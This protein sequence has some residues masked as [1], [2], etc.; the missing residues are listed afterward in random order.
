MEH[1]KI[2][3]AY[4]LPVS[5]RG[6][7]SFIEMAMHLPADNFETILITVKKRPKDP[8]YIDQFGHK[9]FYLF[10]EEQENSRFT[11]G[12][13]RKLVNILKAEKIDILHAHRHRPSSYAC[14]AKLFL[15][16][17][18][19]ISHVHGLQRTRNINRTLQNMLWFSLCDKIIGC[20][21]AVCGD[22]IAHNIFVNQKKVIM[23]ENSVDYNRYASVNI[24]KQQARLNFPENYRNGF[25]LGNVARFRPYKGHDILVKAFKKVL[26]SLPEARLVLVGDGPCKNK[27]EKQIEQANLS[28]F[29]LL[30]GRR[31]DIPNLLRAF[32]LFVLP[33]IDSEGMPLCLLEAMSASIPCIA[34][35]L[36]GIPEVINDEI[37]GHL[38][39]PGDVD[40]LADAMLLYAKTHKEHLE[41]IAKAGCERIKIKFSHDVILQK[42][43]TIYN[44][45][46][47]PDPV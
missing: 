44:S 9:V 40:E 31:N 41:K 1:R 11:F 32:D 42:L 28:R 18:I 13:I 46:M 22:V 7:T 38:V 37:V 29:I 25:I 43:I 6:G 8:D 5:F 45:L 21:N 17:L 14:A 3:V 4:L 47:N 12:A 27:I 24:T 26:A 19:V 35:K 2:K 20:A 39:K 23:L 36:S 10:D 16:P 30:T 33:S 15:K 34:T